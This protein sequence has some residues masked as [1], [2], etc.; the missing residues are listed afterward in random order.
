MRATS[1]HFPENSRRALLDAGL[2]TALGNIPGGFQDKRAAAIAR[3]PEFDALCDAARDIKDHTLEHL[4]FYLE[5]FEAKVT[6][7]GGRVHWCRSPAEA[8]AAVLAICRDAGAQLVIKGKTM[9]GEEI[10]INDYLEANG[11]Q[12]VETDLGEYIVQ[13]R[14]ETPSHIIAPAI[15]LNRGQIADSFLV[16][17]RRLGKTHRLETPRELLEEAREVLRDR[18]LSANVGITGAN[19]LVAETGSAVVVTN[20]GNGDLTLSLPPVHIVVASIDKLVPTLE[21]ACTILRVL[22]RSATGQE[23]TAYTTFATGPRRARDTDGPEEFHVVLLDNGR[24]EMLGSAFRDMLRCIR[25]AAC[26]NHCPVYEAVGGH[27]YGWVYPGPM[28]AV[29]TPWHLGLA[30]A[31][32]LPNASTLCGRC[33]SVCPMR[34][35]LPRMLRLW[36]ER[37]VEQRLSSR[38]LRTGLALW[39]WFAA[40]PWLYHPAAGLAVR[41]LGRLGRRRGR[42]HRLPFAGAWTRARDLPAP[43]GATFQSLWA[44]R[45]REER[46]QDGGRP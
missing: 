27:A 1:R 31:G 33:E 42:F 13:L 39:A 35:P 9:I 44:R 11:V 17:H 12:A 40:R 10:A 14:R 20:E 18:F 32:H 21:D 37:E 16:A 22:A 15:H 6:E 26:M 43:Q 24:A 30:E 34:I 23:F 38:T 29:L 8:R 7:L 19:L 5:T 3:L 4:D 41:L 46:R 2:Q 45:R 28:G 25:C 36:R